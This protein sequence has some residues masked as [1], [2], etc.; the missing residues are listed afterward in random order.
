MFGPPHTRVIVILLGTVFVLQHAWAQ[1]VST[2]VKVSTVACR[3]TPDIGE[4][5]RVS[6]AKDKAAW[7]K[8]IMPRLA[9][10][11][12]VVMDRG[13]TVFIDQRL[14]RPNARPI[15]CIRRAADAEC[16]W[17]TSDVL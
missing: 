9:D 3:A 6:A 8:F 13:T 4:M 1:T 14:V 17:V 15:A 2:I 16:W 7:E 10:K 12:C 5:E 11:R